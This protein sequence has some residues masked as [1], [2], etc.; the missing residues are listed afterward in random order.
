MLKKHRL[1]IAILLSFLIHFITVGVVSLKEKTKKENHNFVD[2]Q[3]LEAQLKKSAESPLDKPMG[4][5]VEQNEKP[6][7]NEIPEDAK[8]LSKNNQRVEK[9]TKAEN[10]GKF[11]NTSG[12]GKPS[13]EVAQ[14]PDSLEAQ[15]KQKSELYPDHLNNGKQK[16]IAKTAN[17]KLFTSEFGEH[18]LPKLSDLKPEFKPS[19]NAFVGGETQG[20]DASATDDHIKDIN[21][22]MQT[23]LS[24]REFIY[25]TYYNRIKARLR[26]YWEPK[27][28]EK[29]G[30]IL[31]QGRTIAST[32]EK[33]TKIVII[34][35]DKG[36][37]EKVQIV[38]PSGLTD[39]DDAAVEAF[40][41]AAPFPNPP[42]GIIEDDGKIR[43]RWD[44]ILEA[45]NDHPG[46]EMYAYGSPY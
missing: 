5:I 17:Q 16:K 24:T 13:E 14:K 31:R 23:L 30:N 9:Q 21:T 3:L 33:I 42:K 46:M 8:F 28:K 7:N 1:K 18:A 12:F 40:R 19:P 27:I 2:I 45:D 11:K 15:A 43:I 10:S 36:T 37:L 20:S 25:Y 29:V 6:F 34:L 38:G 22:G 44:F 26:Q 32:T 35:N 41:A 4:Q 39:L